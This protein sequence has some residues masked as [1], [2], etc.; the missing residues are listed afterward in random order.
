MEI[1][2]WGLPD[3]VYLSEITITVPVPVLITVARVTFVP[4]TVTHYIA[5]ALWVMFVPA[6]IAHVVAIALHA[7]FVD[8]V[9]VLVPLAALTGNT[10]NVQTLTTL[11][12]SYDLFIVLIL[13]IRREEGVSLACTS[14]LVS[15]ERGIG[16]TTMIGLQHLTLAP[17]SFGLF[18]HDEAQGV[19]EELD[20]VAEGVAGHEGH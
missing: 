6:A 2:C 13:A 19:G 9:P 20:R 3:L 18:C 1:S 16:D 14:R 15:S 8:I 17:Q 5:V 7:T 10:C 11:L 4:V 12:L